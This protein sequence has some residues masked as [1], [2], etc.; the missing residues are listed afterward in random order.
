FC[1]GH[2]S[3]KLQEAYYKPTEKEVLED[4][5]RAVDILTIN[6][7]FMLQMKVKE[8]TE[9]GKDSEYIIKGKLEEKDKQIEVLTKKQE[10]FE[11]LIQSLVDTGQL[12][13]KDR[14][15]KLSRL[16]NKTG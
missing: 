7:E 8:L 1:M 10:Q 14:S 3:D 2:K 12:I 5:L 16:S 9:K 15:E 11:S 4:Y 6:E 13:V